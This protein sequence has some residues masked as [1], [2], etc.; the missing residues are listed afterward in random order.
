MTRSQLSHVTYVSPYTI[1]I[2]YD[3]LVLADGQIPDAAMIHMIRKK[4]QQRAREM[5]DEFIPIDEKA[6]EGSS[7]RLIR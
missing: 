3:P 4:R 6:K 1:Q 2:L 7:S 5:T